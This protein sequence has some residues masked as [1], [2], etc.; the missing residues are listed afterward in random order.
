ME[1]V[2]TV[3][4]LKNAE[5]LLRMTMIITLLVAGISKFCSHGNFHRYYLK[6]FLNPGLRINLP[7]LLVDLY[8]TLIP[9]IEVSIAIA[10]ILPFKRRFFIVLWIIYFLSLEIGHYVLEE[11]TSVDLIISIILFGVAAYILP[12][13]ELFRTKSKGSTEV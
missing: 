10:L 2:I 7:S 12:A 13:H 4:T 3:K 1:N 6:L 11:F 9:F 8:I 5:L